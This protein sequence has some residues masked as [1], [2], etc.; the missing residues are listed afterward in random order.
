MSVSNLE[1]YINNTDI[2]STGNLKSRTRLA[3]LYA[4]KNEVEK[5]KKVLSPNILKTIIDSLYDDNYAIK[6]EAIEL[7]VHLE[8]IEYINLDFISEIYHNLTF[9]MAKALYQYNRKILGLNDISTFLKVDSTAFLKE[10]EE[11]MIYYPEYIITSSELFLFNNEIEGAEEKINEFWFKDSDPSPPPHSTDWLFEN[12]PVFLLKT[13]RLGYWDGAR[14][15]YYLGNFH[16]LYSEN[17]HYEGLRQTL[18][19]FV[20][21]ITEHVGPG[22]IYN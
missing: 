10:K 20:S 18:N 21:L 14:L 7:L 12:Y 5:V 13:I 17:E 16:D 2:I 22:S 4:I 15:P 3:I 1:K 6:I 9:E 8:K 19:L 11:D